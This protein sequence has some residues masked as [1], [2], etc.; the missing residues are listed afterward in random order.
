MATDRS[1]PPFDPLRDGLG[2][3]FTYIELRAEEGRTGS[4][5]DMTWRISDPEEGARM[6]LGG[7]VAARHLYDRWPGHVFGGADGDLW[8]AA[9]FFKQRPTEHMERVVD[10]NVQRVAQ[11]IEQRWGSV[12]AIANTLRRRSKVTYAEAVE[13]AA[14][15]QPATPRYAVPTWKPLVDT[16]LRYMEIDDRELRQMISQ[17][18]RSRW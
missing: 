11:I 7:I 3:T 16:V 13:I 17:L 2:R 18:A 6:K 9:D 5:Q 12:R 15:A 14:S 1:G 8:A 10:W 4:V